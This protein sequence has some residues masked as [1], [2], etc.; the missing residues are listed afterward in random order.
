MF[1]ATASLESLT[2][3]HCRP[4]LNAPG[5]LAAR[6]FSHRG[7]KGLFMTLRQKRITSAIALFLVFATTQVYV[8]VSFAGPE[9][10]SVRVEVTAPAPQQVT[11][12]LS[13]QGN[14]PI[15]VNGANAISGA[16]IVSGASVETP[17]GV[18]GTVNLGSLGSLQI[19]PNS[20][21]T[22]EFQNGSVK[23]MLLQGCVTLHTKKGTSGEVDTSQGVLGTSDVARD[24]L[25]KVCA[26]GSVATAP[27]AA[28]GPGGLFGLGTAATVAI[29]AGG[30][31]AVI[32]P[33][34][35]R[36]AN[37]SPATL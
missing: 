17:D 14:K 25:I 8:G 32:V 11:G 10:N 37:P 6:N 1:I 21:L 13:T 29:I 30:A 18:G 20:K 35:T 16:T 3:M 31:T 22:L 5:M 27:A 36:G 24:G 12:S 2:R 23:V 7:R 15:T 28:A 33:I 19:D 4:I 26:P 9:P 34:V